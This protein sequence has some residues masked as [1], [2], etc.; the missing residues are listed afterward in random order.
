M[1]GILAQIQ[2]EPTKKPI[3]MMPF[4]IRRKKVHFFLN[5]DTHAQLHHSST[6]ISMLT[7]T[8]NDVSMRLQCCCQDMSQCSAKKSNDVSRIHL[9]EV[10][11]F[12][13]KVAL[14]KVD[15]RMLYCSWTTSLKWIRDTSLDF[16]VEHC[17]MS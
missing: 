15:G 17:D 1:E 5:C 7:N 10:V 6:R 13:F 8:S 12:A 2:H 4:P 3:T 11:L 16:S 9:N 14:R